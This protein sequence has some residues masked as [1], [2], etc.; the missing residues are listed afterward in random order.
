MSG[1]GASATGCSQ[2]SCPSAPSLVPTPAVGCATKRTVCFGGKWQVSECTSCT[3]A[4]YKMVET[5]YNTND[6]CGTIKFNV[7]QPVGTDPDPGFCLINVDSTACA[8]FVINLSNCASQRTDCFG[9][10]K[11]NTCLEC[12]TGYEK[13]VIEKTFSDCSN[14]YSQTTC[15]AQDCPGV[16]CTLPKVLDPATCT[17]K[18]PLACAGD[19]V[20]NF[21]CECACPVGHYEVDALTCETCPEYVE[22]PEGTLT[23]CGVFANNNDENGITN[24]YYKANQWG[25]VKCSYSDDTGKFQYDSNCY[26]SE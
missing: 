6:T 3:D 14:T 23:L 26:Y 19:K 24:C 1:Y 22:P 13:K 2:S 9:T 10:H 17:C 21:D 18:C 20:Q 15:E 5:S 4:T 25:T 8:G 16:T 7:C 12:A 11:I